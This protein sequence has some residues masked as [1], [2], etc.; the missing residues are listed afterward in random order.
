MK[1][2]HFIPEMPRDDKETFIAG[3]MRQDNG[4]AW[5]WQRRWREGRSRGRGKCLSRM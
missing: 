3:F 1:D 5:S 2:G 4:T